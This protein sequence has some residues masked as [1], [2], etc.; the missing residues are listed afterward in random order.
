METRS[1]R[2]LNLLNIPTYETTKGLE[3][4]LKEKGIRLMNEQNFFEEKTLSTHMSTHSDL[5][6]DKTSGSEY[7]PS[8]DDSVKSCNQSNKTD[9]KNVTIRIKS[10]TR[11]TVKR[12][13]VNKKIVLQKNNNTADFDQ[14]AIPDS[15]TSPGANDIALSPPSSFDNYSNEV[16]SQQTSSTSHVRKRA[17]AIGAHAPRII[18]AT[19]ENGKLVRNKAY[20]CYFCQRIVQNAARH[21]E[22][23][24]NKE[25]DVAKILAKPKHS[26]E[27][28]DGFRNLIRVGN[29]YHNTEV[30]A[31]NRGHLILVRRPTENELKFL[32]PADY[33]PC[34]YCLGFMLKKHL[35]HHV[36][37]SCTAKSQK[38]DQDNGRHIIAESHALLNDAFGREFSTDYVTNIVCK[39]RN[40]DIGTYCNEDVL[41]QRFGS[42]LFEKYGTTQCELIR[43]S[44]RQL[45]R[46]TLKLGEID[47][48]KRQLTDFLVPQMFDLIIQAT[49]S[50]C[51]THQNVALRPEFELPSLALKIGYALKKCA[52]IKRGSCLR[53][54]NLSG[55]ETLL[56]FLSLMDLE[57]NTRVSSSALATMYNRKMNAAELLPLTSDLIKLSSYLN[58]EMTKEQIFLSNCATIKTWSRLASLTL[59][60]IILFNK[61][62]SGE[63]ARMTIVA[64]S[65]RPNWSSQSTEKLKKSLT[66]FERKL[67]DKLTLVEI[68]GKRGRK[69]PVL[70]TED[71]KSSVDKLIHIR[72][73]VNIS[74]KNPFIFARTGESFLSL[75]GHD[76]LRKACIDAGL[77]SPDNITSTKL[78]KYT[79]T[80]CQVFNLSETDY[81]WIA[82]HLGHDIRVHR[83]FYRLHESAIE[84][85][86]VSRILLAVEKG[87][88]NKFAGKSLDEINLDDIPTETL[89]SDEEDEDAIPTQASIEENEDLNQSGTI[90][91]A[92]IVSEFV[93]SPVVQ[94][95][96]KE[97]VAK[98]KSSARRPWSS[99]EK[100]FVLKFFISSIKRGTVPGKS[101]CTK[102]IEESNG[103]L[104]LR[105]WTDV[106]FCVKNHLDK[107]KKQKSKMF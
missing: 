18:A 67:A 9:F 97:A 32:T 22:L 44:M 47:N 54:G 28:K 58:E 16:G 92:K 102:C 17:S 66:D 90:K 73:D 13:R 101:D 36:K 81:D 78:R 84:L 5:S 65:S 80:V 89:Q 69:V 40:D 2:I 49:K 77:A 1:R 25:T 62:R 57:W 94:V 19:K 103:I 33:G 52:A 4:D 10:K 37:N 106:K 11:K 93:K 64:Y 104:A 27:R 96:Q 91:K 87:Q 39:L 86:K 83:E 21:F 3:D 51:V 74:V 45:A 100:Q 79:A 75:R 55:N 46:L 14:N 15:T 82:R 76:C 24:H 88:V 23:L 85:T 34:P 41:I 48:S 30:L 50:L 59:S 105:S 7:L 26:K 63:S 43:Q 70:L 12:N 8:E 20:A 72:G 56:C 38:D 53:G 61:R 99:D 60:K 35:W 71:V 95:A 42:M 29:F 31:T 68:V 6:E 107:L 98:S